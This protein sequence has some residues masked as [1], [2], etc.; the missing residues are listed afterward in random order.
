[1]HMTYGK[2]LKPGTCAAD[3]HGVDLDKD[4]RVFIKCGHDTCKTIRYLQA[5]S[6]PLCAGSR[7]DW[8][9]G[10]GAGEENSLYSKTFAGSDPSGSSL[11][12]FYGKDSKR[13]SDP[14]IRSFS[15]KRSG[16]WL[17]AR[18][19]L[20][21]LSW[22]TALTDCQRKRSFRLINF[23]YLRRYGKRFVQTDL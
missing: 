20:E 9:A 11:C 12:E 5:P 2:K 3:Q 1:M 6:L 14:S 16:A 22:N 15:A 4:R 8:E 21:A 7:T 18:I 23:W 19:V 13:D 17:R 10:S